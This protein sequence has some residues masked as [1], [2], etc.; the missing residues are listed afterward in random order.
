MCQED[1]TGCCTTHCTA[2]AQES[3]CR[4]H[5]RSLHGNK[6]KQILS[7]DE[8]RHKSVSGR[9]VHTPTVRHGV[10]T[11]TARHGVLTPT[12]RHDTCTRYTTYIFPLH[13][14]RT[15]IARRAHAHCA[16]CTEYVSKYEHGVR[17]EVRTCTRRKLHAHVLQE[18]IY[19]AY[20]RSP[21]QKL[22]RLI[23]L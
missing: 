9:D 19:S 16:T 12:A 13:D 2:N 5:S 14:V 4:L 20:V 22:I 10:H 6:G 17:I 23:Y 15:P 3:W 7:L 18:D 8:R 21:S 1:R 11:P